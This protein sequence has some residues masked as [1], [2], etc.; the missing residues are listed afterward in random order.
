MPMPLATAI[1]FW[2]KVSFTSG[3]W[4]WT[5]SVNNNGYG[6]AASGREGQWVLAHRKSWEYENGPIPEGKLVLHECDTPRCVRP[7]HLFLGTKL[8]N[9][10]DMVNKGRQWCQKLMP[11]DIRLIKFMAAEGESRKDIAESFKVSVDTIRWAIVG[12]PPRIAAKNVEGGQDGS[13]D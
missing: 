1:D 9:A 6:K 11:E 10:R 2:K 8:T 7:S 4:F 12:R 5:G 13:T 3:C